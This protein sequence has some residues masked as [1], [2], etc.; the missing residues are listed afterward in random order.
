VTDP[1]K[2]EF[3][4]VIGRTVEES[5]P[6]WPEPARPPA[7]APNVVV[8][9][10]DDLGFA[11]LGCYGSDIATP[12]IDALAENGVRYNNFHTTAICSPT[13]ASL[14]TGRNPHAAGVSFV[15]EH[16][17][18]FPNIRGKVGKDSALISEIL[19]EHGYN[20]FAVGKWHLAPGAEHSSAGPFDNWPLG[21]GFDRF[22][23]F[24]GGATSQWQPD[25]VEDN[26]RV[27]QPKSPEEGYHLTEDLTDKAIE[28]IRDQKSAAPDKPF[29][30]YV[31]YG[32]T[33]APHHAPKAYIDKYKGKY[34]KGWDAVR[35]EWFKR[36]Q[37]LGLIPANAKLPPRNPGVRAWD[38][39]TQ[40]EQRL[41][42]RLQEAFAGFLEHTDEQ[43]GR[44]VEFLRSIG[45]L[46]NTLFILLSDNG[47][48]AMGGEHG[49]I[50]SW[51]EF[52]G[53][54]ETFES[55]LK[56]IDEIGTPLA[57]NHYPAGWAQ[58]GNTPLKWY[59][60]FV[61][62]GGVKDPL[63]IHYPAGLKEKG[64]VRS[65][66]H[67]VSD[68]VPTILEII[69]IEAPSIYKGVPQEPIHGVSMAYS[70]NDADAPTRKEIQVYEMVGNRAIY[71]QG[72]KA[73]AV[74]KP[75]TS[76]EEDEW[77]LYHIDEDYS[78]MNDLAR[79][80]PEKLQ[81]LIALWWKEA[82]TK[83]ILPLDGR[84]VFAKVRAFRANRKEPAGP[85]RRIY[86]PSSQALHGSVA[87]D[88]RSK[89]FSIT[90]RIE[91]PEGFGD[92]VLVSHGDNSG[93]YVWYIRDGK[94]HFYYNF[95]GASSYEI[96]ASESL[97]EGTTDLRFIV[98]HSDEQN[99]IGRL[100]AGERLIGEGHLGNLQGLGFGGGLF[101]IGR[102]GYSIVK[103]GL[104]AP[105]SFT[106]TIHQVV[107]TL[108]GYEPD[109]EALLELELASE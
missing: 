8:V 56:R 9:L 37:A 12:N 45:Q 92:G 71:H 91:R 73:V 5:V 4:G 78:E 107:Y 59:K 28:L 62:A 86:Y 14:L 43:I 42:A 25:L 85:V 100:Y 60:S 20:T 61:H 63:I 50:N 15:A 67:H 40:D 81:E 77:E 54:K 96:A 108:G 34:D 68:I 88:L 69:G 21:R 2:G 29:F 98:L 99:G 47:A 93:G 84:S 24:L 87:P 7:G 94:P 74:H 32:A 66:Y 22:Y 6:W 51:A 64:G 23:G 41:Y 39:L 76:F 70:L 27:T 17:G 26:R 49:T 57:N 11:H 72:W 109:L 35:E 13:R 55:K 38:S 89:P 58:A 53:T 19:R 33:H 31:A 102:S 36:Q 16:D 75:D 106:G 104:P 80:Y 48:C 46:D 18:G 10:L 52:G 103:R 95:S 83:K 105:Y 3:Q 65:Q 44:L 79:V 97:S 30:A 1:S 90:A 82:E 101:H